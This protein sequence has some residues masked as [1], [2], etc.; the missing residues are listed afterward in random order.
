M[1]PLKATSTQS[2]DQSS[3][4]SG[5]PINTHSAIIRKMN[6]REGWWQKSVVRRSVAAVQFELQRIIDNSP[7]LQDSTPNDFAVF[8]RS[9]IQTGSMIG[10]G[11]FSEVYEITGF[12][13]DPDV[14]AKCTITQ[15]VLREQC[16]GAESGRFALK[17]LKRR[18]IL[19]PKAFV[20]AATDLA[21][22]A[23]YMSHLDHPNILAVRGLPVDGLTAFDDGDHDGYFLITD[24]LTS[25]VGDRIKEWKTSVDQVPSVKE[26]ALHALQI[27]SALGYLHSNRIVFRDLKPQNMGFA[28]NTGDVQLFDFGLCRELPAQVDNNEDN[29]NGVYDMSGVG[30]RRYMAPEIINDECYN[31][32][33]DVYS[34]SMLTW[35]LLTGCKPYAL[36]TMDEHRVIVCQGGER[37]RLHF[38]WP[39]WLQTLLR[40]TWC[41]SV[42]DR[43][44]ID[45]V[46]AHL[47]GALRDIAP[48]R[49]SSLLDSP[50]GVHEFADD[51]DVVADLSFLAVPELARSTGPRRISLNP[52]L[53]SPEGDDTSS[54]FTTIID[55]SLLGL[56]LDTDE[57]IEVCVNGDNTFSLTPSA[58]VLLPRRRMVPSCSI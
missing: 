16:A 19:S 9:E 54:L 53:L 25:T 4:S 22:E 7:F 5:A 27:A 44:S 36:Y 38:D 48:K 45:Q 33:V 55:N 32:K 2:T 51:S 29:I 24:R 15:Q 21:V 10:M 47:T 46:V 39:E 31:L 14:T 41:E 6:D 23:T 13:L 43:W 52:R 1:N 8:H 20:S 17:H 35:E 30:T 49:P 57:G 11:G 26:K 40:K 3:S 28:A 37:P 42:S 18:L 12:N 50:V 34:W 56:T 58:P